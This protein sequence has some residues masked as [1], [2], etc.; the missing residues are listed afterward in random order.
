MSK[1]RVL[2]IE[3]EELQRRILESYLS[4]DPGIEVVGSCSGGI[5]AIEL[6]SS[7]KPDAVYLDI[8]LT[9]MNGMSTASCLRTID[10][11]ARLVFVTGHT[12]YA[13]EA[14]NVE[15]IDYLIKPINEDMLKR[16]IGR[17]RKSIEQNN[18]DNKIAKS[19]KI[20][21][22]YKRE[23]F[24]IDQNDILFIEHL[25]RFSRIHTLS[26]IFETYEPLTAIAK[27][28]DS[29]FFRCHRSYIVNVSKIIRINTISDRMYEASFNNYRNSVPMNRRAFEMLC[30][31]LGG[32]NQ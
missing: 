11:S 7:M 15:A 8:E 2:V 25:N 27:R 1:L 21:I 14:F 18:A 5:R 10:P 6:Y 24:F 20:V 26:E 12:K 16:S 23:L 4:L 3:D 31:H 17:I 32:I 19:D 28:L 30:E 13:A 22:R 9:D 29:N